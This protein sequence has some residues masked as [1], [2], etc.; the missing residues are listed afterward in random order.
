LTISGK[1]TS[2]FASILKLTGAYVS[3][4]TDSTTSTYNVCIKYDKVLNETIRVGNH[5]RM[6]IDN[7]DIDA[8]LYENHGEPWLYTSLNEGETKSYTFDV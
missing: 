1:R 4:E 3:F 5:R 7:N 6:E 8:H 2:E